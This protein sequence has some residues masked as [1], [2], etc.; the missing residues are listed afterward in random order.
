M[1]D[2]RKGPLPVTAETVRRAAQ[3]LK[4]GRLVAFPT[5]TVY[6]LG[7]SALDPS[8]V[9]RIFEAKRRPA[10]DPLIVHTSDAPSAFDLCSSVP[11]VARQLAERYWPGPLTLVLPKTAVVPDVVTSG[12]PTVAVRVPAHPVA[13]ELIRAF[14]GPVAAPSANLFGYTSPTHAQAVLDDLGDRV[15]LV[16]DGGACSVGIESTVLLVEGQKGVLLRPGGIP[17]EELR[18]FLPVEKASST[19]LAP[20][21]PGQLESHY[22]PWTTLLLCEGGNAGVY[23]AASALALSAAEEG[24]PRPRLGALLFGPQPSDIDDVLDAA[25]NLSETGDLRSAATRLF[26][27]IRALDKMNLDL[28]LASTVPDTGIGGAINDRLIR[29]S[30]R[31]SVPAAGTGTEPKDPIHGN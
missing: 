28:L 14:G 11:P 22:A 31:P 27:A 1:P 13:L 29:A 23:R 16:L 15:D 20:R 5:E 7:A 24:R 6:G 26:A 12:L 17:V 30:R 2:P 10:F 25:E 3:A 8:A 9:V 19:P 21:S 4:E 18:E